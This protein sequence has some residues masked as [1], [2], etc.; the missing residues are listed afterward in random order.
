MKFI[1]NP[2]NQFILFILIFLIINL[3]QSI[4]TGLLDDEAYYWVWAKDLDFG[5]FDHPPLVAVWIKLSSLLFNGEL[6][7]RFMSTI[8]FSLTLYI[9]WKC[10][11]DQRKWQYVWLFFLMVSSMGLLNAY[12]FITVPDTPLILFTA[13]FLY[14]YKRFLETESISSTLIMGFAMSAMLYSKYHGVLVILFVLLSNLSLLKSRKFWLASIFG[15]ILFIPH[16]MWQIEQDFPSF[17]FHLI[18]RGSKPYRLEYTMMYFVNLMAIVGLTF[19]IIYFAFIKKKAQTQ[20]QKSLKYIVWGFLLFFFLATFR[21]WPEAQWNML[22]FLPILILTFDFYI[23]HIKVRKWL[24]YLGLTNF[25]LIMV[26]RLFMASAEL[27]PI[28]FET[29]RG[30]EWAD[31]IKTQTGERPV[32]FISSYQSASKYNYYTGIKTHSYSIIRKRKSHYDLYNFEQEMQGENVAIVGTDIDGYALYK[33]GKKMHY[34]QNIDHYRTLQKINFDIA[35]NPMVLSKSAKKEVT[36]EIHNPYLED[37]DFKDQRFIGVFQKQKKD[38]LIIETPLELITTFSLKPDE[39]I[40]KKAYFD[41][42]E[43]IVDKT[44]TFR[45]A[46]KYYQLPGGFQGNK[47]NVI[48]KDE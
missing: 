25:V 3:V 5:Y 23:E 21:M 47:V 18:E 20:Y 15:A 39:K 27:S 9:L 48:L 45:V 37:V 43:N 14:A 24:I 34:G 13:L 8:S 32:V 42:P 1:P 35:E 6:G 40:L 44:F 30:K 16:I 19:P 22:I 2:K 26:A 12:G 36:F 28:E 29:H 17:K 7:V 38:T 46:L 4:Y 41:V 31:N 33:K 11:D 10:I